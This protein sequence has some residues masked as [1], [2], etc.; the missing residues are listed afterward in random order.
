MLDSHQEVKLAAHFDHHHGVISRQEALALG[1]S[2]TQVVRL[3]TSGRWQRVLPGVYAPSGVALRA[4][5]RL[6]AACLYAGPAAVA[7]HR[8]AA[9]LWGLLPAPAVPAVST[10]R[11]RPRPRPGLEV[12]LAEDLDEKRVRTWHGF[13][14]TDPLRALADLGAVAGRRELTDAVDRAVASGLVTLDGLEAEIGRLTRPGR[15]GVASL[16]EV[17][18]CR[19][20]SGAP[21][22][23]VLES[24][25]LRLLRQWGLT[26]VGV[27]QRV[28]DGRYRVDVLL[29]DCVVLEVDGFAYHWSPEAKAADS[30]RRN[31][32]RRAGFTV[33]ESDWVEVMRHPERFRLTVTG[34]VDAARAGPAAPPEPVDTGCGGGT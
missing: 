29:A 4:A 2:P 7:S 11:G 15:R 13:R 24:R 16:R 27:Q 14:T 8:S 31:E 3:H 1:L 33:I 17:L 22:P 6:T 23:S 5:G 25:V 21:A 10:R 34:G 12:H 20:M 19:G 26:P 9:W 28:V 18:D 32:L 30:L